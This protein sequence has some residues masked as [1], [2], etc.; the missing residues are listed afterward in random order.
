MSTV[1]ATS[2]G[3]GYNQNSGAIAVTPI[4]VDKGHWWV[5]RRGHA[6]RGI[7]TPAWHRVCVASS[8]G[9]Q[10]IGKVLHTLDSIEW[11]ETSGLN[12]I[13]GGVAG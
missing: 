3:A 8:H 4:A 9:L 13:H 6:D 11:S 7:A 10:F 1:A 12:H 5:G 2:E